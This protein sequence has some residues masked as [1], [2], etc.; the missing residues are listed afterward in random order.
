[1]QARA[2]GSIGK[3]NPRKRRKIRKI[4]SDMKF[5]CTYIEKKG[6]ENSG[7]DLS[8]RSFENSKAIFDAAKID[9]ILSSP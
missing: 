4:Y 1:M 7:K 2:A 8:D 3:G 9:D 6:K 5:F